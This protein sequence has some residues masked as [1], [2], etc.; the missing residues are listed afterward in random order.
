M[1]VCVWCCTLDWELGFGCC[2]HLMCIWREQIP[3]VL[4]CLLQNIVLP[5]MFALFVFVLWEQE[6]VYSCN[7][8]ISCAPDL[9]QFLDEYLSIKHCRSDLFACRSWLTF[10]PSTMCRACVLW[11]DGVC[12][13]SVPL[14]VLC[15]SPVVVVTCQSDCFYGHSKKFTSLAFAAHFLSPSHLCAKNASEDVWTLW[16]YRKWNDVGCLEIFCH[17]AQC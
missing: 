9:L 8:F 11:L 17:T 7:S 2:L 4:C 14:A 16:A 12:T 6:L 15:F 5:D 13:G 10:Q 1:C 3:E